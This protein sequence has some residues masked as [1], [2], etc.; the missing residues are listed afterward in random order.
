MS[1]TNQNILEY[2]GVQFRLKREKLYFSQKDIAD[3]TGI[4]TNTISTV[5]RGKGTTLNNFLSI[6]RALHIQ[7]KQLFEQDMDL[8]PLY[9]LPPLNKR[10]LEIT[11]KLD[12]LVY[13]SDFF[14][15]PK[16]VSEVLSALKSDKTESNKFSVYLASYCKEDVLEYTKQGN[17]NRYSKKR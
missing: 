3:M 7:P 1:R 6:C 2:I 5:E 13:N 14:D 16:R 9:E 17:F 10:R 4:T 15:T 8:T 12:D 11:Q